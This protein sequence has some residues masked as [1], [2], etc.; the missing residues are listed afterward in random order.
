MEET[1][2]RFVITAKKNQCCRY[3]GGKKEYYFCDGSSSLIGKLAELMSVYGGDNYSVLEVQSKQEADGLEIEWQ[4]ETVY[5]I[6]GQ[7]EPEH[8][9]AADFENDEMNFADYL[10][11]DCGDWSLTYDEE[12]DL[13][14]DERV[15]ILKAEDAFSLAIQEAWGN[16]W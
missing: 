5:I 10:I 3:E 9:V 12:D 11:G 15:E 8:K 7:A 14:E 2:G 6:T 16:L 4:G 13:D 1:E